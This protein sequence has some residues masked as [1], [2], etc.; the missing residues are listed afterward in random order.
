[1][2][3]IRLTASSLVRRINDSIR[4]APSQVFQSTECVWLVL[5]DDSLLRPDTGGQHRLERSASEFPEEPYLDCLVAGAGELCRGDDRPAGL[6]LPLSRFLYSHYSIQLGE[7]YLND[8][9]MIRSSI[10]L[11]K[12][13]LLP[14]FEQEFALAAAV[15]RSEGVAFW[16]PQST[17]TGLESRFAA[18]D[19]ELIAILPRALAVAPEPG[20]A[21]DYVVA[22]EDASSHSLIRI[23]G[24]V[25]TQVLSAYSEEFDNEDLRSAW[26]EQAAPLMAESPISMSTADDWLAFRDSKPGLPGYLL[27]TRSFLDKV[28]GRNRQRRV[29]A[30]GAA[31]FATAVI[32][33]LPFVYQWV[34]TLRLERARDAYREEARVAASYQDEL[35][36]MEYEWGVVYEYPEVDAGAVLASLNTVIDNSLTSFSLGDSNVEIQGFTSD[37]ENLTRLLVDLPLFENIEQ[38]RSISESNSGGDRFGLRMTVAD[39]DYEEYF[40]KYEFR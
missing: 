29:V 4:L 36:D 1:M 12:D 40:R 24:Q 32:L 3:N 2:R 22:D 20:P 13:I 30:G 34:D 7:E 10:A 5:L 17:L 35:L 11:Q 31:A 8:R 27:Y 33:A 28:S 19:L 15:G 9:D 39:H 26:E 21:T 16:F 23:E 38:S 18:A 37:P 14:A 6:L 25:A